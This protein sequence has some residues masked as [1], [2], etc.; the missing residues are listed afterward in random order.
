MKA[1]FLDRDGTINVEVNYLHKIEDLV[2]IP[3]SVEAIRLLNEN[4]YKVL[5]VTNQAG[6]ARGFYTE[7]EVE[8]LH[9]QIQKLLGK[10]GAFIDA[11]F[12]SP[13]HPTEG[14]GKYLKDSPCRKPGTLMLERGISEFGISVENSFLIGDSKSDI[15]AGNKIGLTTILVETGYGLKHLNQCK[16]DFI[17]KDLW[18]AVH[19][20]VLEKLE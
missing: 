7:K 10:E 20:V 5:V 11:F 6:I 4:G 2:F 16:P 13:F 18:T 15:E 3:K 12:F 17:K 19:E 1:V 8:N 14:V 9:N